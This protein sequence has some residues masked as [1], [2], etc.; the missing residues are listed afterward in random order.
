MVTSLNTATLKILSILLTYLK[1][2][3]TTESI[4]AAARSNT[5]IVGPNPTQ[6]MVVYL[7]LFCVCVGSGPLRLVDPPYKESY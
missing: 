5:E 1:A 6:C 2:A 7:C 4:T 3:Y